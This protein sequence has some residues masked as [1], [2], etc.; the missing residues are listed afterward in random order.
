[1]TYRAITANVEHAALIKRFYDENVDALHGRDIPLEEWQEMVSANDPD[2]INY[3][4]YQGDTPAGWFRINGL[5]DRGGTLWLS[6]LAIGENF[7]RQGAGRFAV[8]FAEEYA[9]S[10]GYS[11]LGIHTTMDNL[12]AQ[13]LYSNCGCVMTEQSECTNGD[14]QTREGCT[15]EK[16]LKE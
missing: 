5:D 10:G 9:R 1:M 2:E 6:M 15:F 11:L 12:P 4:I 13:S 16:N 7:H 8:T 14:G 3:I